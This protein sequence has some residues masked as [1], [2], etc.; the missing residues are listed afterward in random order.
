MTP[1][2]AQILTCPHCGSKKEV[3]SLASGNTFG[4]TVWSDN[5]SIAPMLPRVSFVQKCPSCGHYYIMSRQKLEHGKDY[6]GDLGELSYSEL[7]EAWEELGNED[8]TD[9]EKLSM[10]IMQVWAF[11]DEFTRTEEKPVSEEEKR[12]IVSIVNSLLELDNVDG[13]LKAELLR[14]IGRFDEALELIGGYNATNDFLK[15]LQK[16]FVDSAKAHNTRP[17][18][19]VPGY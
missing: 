15:G 10:L 2:F 19:I 9:D 1:G 7:K 3:L 8:L 16:R 6:S 4:Q 18:I 14:E 11:N 17:F 5:K 13:L 12:Y